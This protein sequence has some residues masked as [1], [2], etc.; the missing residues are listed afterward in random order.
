MPHDVRMLFWDVDP[1]SIDLARHRDYVLERVMT[2]GGWEAMRWLRR[3][4]TDGELREFL[5]RCGSRLRPRDL[6]YWGLVS[7]ARVAPGPGG[8]RP[9]WSGE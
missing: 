8:G 2:R 5:E 4:Y 9:R 3:N 7:G 6:A 1:P